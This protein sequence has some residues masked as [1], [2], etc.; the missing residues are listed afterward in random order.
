MT[1]EV[2]LFR[3]P[4]VESTFDYSRD[5]FIDAL[6]QKNKYEDWD[7]DIQLVGSYQKLYAE[8]LI[9][10]LRMQLRKFGRKSLEIVMIE[11][12]EPYMYYIAM[13]EA[14]VQ[15]LYPDKMP[16]PVLP[17]DTPTPPYRYL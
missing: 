5:F 15:P 7:D 4:T 14:Q 8:S 2:L 11:T 3:E 10:E 6:K 1:A 17:P 16:I 9:R 13:R 12:H